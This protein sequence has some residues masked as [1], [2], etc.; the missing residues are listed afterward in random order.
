[1]LLAQSQ[2]GAPFRLSVIFFSPSQQRERAGRAPGAGRGTQRPGC[3]CAARG[4][5]WSLPSATGAGCRLTDVSPPTHRHTG[6]CTHTRTRTHA[7]TRSPPGRAWRTGL[8][9][10]FTLL[11]ATRERG[12]VPDAAPG[13]PV[14]L[15][16]TQFAGT[17]TKSPTTFRGELG[18]PPFRARGGCALLR[19]HTELA[20]RW[21]RQ[22]WGGGPAPCWRLQVLR[23]LSRLAHESGW[24]LANPP[25]RHSSPVSPTG[26][27]TTSAALLQEET[28][29][30]P[31]DQSGP[32]SSEVRFSNRTSW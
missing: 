16:H 7:C 1:M 29:L 27:Q 2:A 11:P 20:G 22:G 23:P 18:N 31:D 12:L 10:T 21:G 19:L 26:E 8:V 4:G 3:F 5:R 17:V 15:G 30:E 13:L 14:A 24:E 6:V 28:V 9:S 32:L 25:P